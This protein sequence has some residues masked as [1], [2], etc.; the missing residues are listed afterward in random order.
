MKTM[1]WKLG[2]VGLLFAAAPALADSPF[3][4]TWKARLDS[5]K[6]IAKPDRFS[7]KDGVYSCQS[8][9]PA[10]YSIPAD[11]KYHRVA[12]KDYWDEL[13]VTVVDDRSI[14]MS[15]KKAGAVI[16]TNTQSVSA[17]GMTLTGTA[18]NTNNGGN[19][20]IDSTRVTSRVGAPVAGA[21][22]ISGSW[23]AAPASSVSE[24]AMTVS[25]KIDGDR[26]H[27]VTGM[28]ET[29]DATIG[30]PF[31]P[32]VGDPGKTMTKVER[33]GPRSIR[34]TDMRG[35]KV[36]DVSTFTVSADGATLTGSWRDPVSGATGG[37]TAVKSEA[38]RR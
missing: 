27:Q 35:G 37:F 7:I 13:A 23:Q 5:M 31:T 1:L 4:G 33:L 30:G 2:A 29:L 8:C 12:G 22:L 18:R 24:A 17:D 14:G 3:D 16:S 6:M 11:G 25:I 19:V 9:L 38:A 34:T 26:F 10:P 28:G 15:F 21:H 20:P 36:V 32:V